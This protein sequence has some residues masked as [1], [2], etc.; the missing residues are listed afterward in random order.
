MGLRKKATEVRATAPAR[1]FPCADTRTSVV[2]EDLDGEDGEVD[3]GDGGRIVEEWENAGD[4]DRRS[5]I[6]ERE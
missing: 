4:W 2:V 1:R 5:R 6:A 3:K